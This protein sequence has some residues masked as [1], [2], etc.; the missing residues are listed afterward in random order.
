MFISHSTS[1]DDEIALV[2]DALAKGLDA[3]N[4]T[5]LLDER[6]QEPGR[7]WQ[8]KLAR[9][10]GECDAALVLVNE[11]ALASSWVRRETNILHWRKTL[12]PGM[13]LV[14][15]LVGGVSAGQ[16]R[17]SELRYLAD[18]DVERIRA[19]TKDEV[20]RLVQRF[21]QVRRIWD[22][23]VSAWLDDIGI[24]LREIKDESIFAR[25]AR[26][27]DVPEEELVELVPGLAP[28]LLASQMLDTH[29]VVKLGNA[30][31][32]ARRGGLER[33]RV[34]QLATMILPVWVDRDEARRIVRETDGSVRRVVILN[35]DSPEIGKQYLDRAF[36]VDNR[37]YY[38]ATAAGRP[39]GDENPE[40]YLLEQCELAVKDRIGMDPYQELGRPKEPRNFGR[41]FLVLDVKRCDLAMVHRVIARLHEKVPWVHVLVI[42]GRGVDV[43]ERW[44][45]SPDEV[46]VLDPP[47][48]ASHEILVKAVM[49]RVDECVQPIRR[50]AW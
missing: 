6:I 49:R 16:L 40:D 34:G 42:P 21:P 13:V 25:I 50:G 17:A 27:L 20:D 10:L 19:W 7:P 18:D 9:L 30:V 4:H 38:V 39:P 8:L 43:R 23:A 11:A 36:C 15:V 47:F 14:T 41:L 32:V 45:G 1:S 12:Y 22:D 29:D 48:E 37:S 46:L 31:L 35:V 5:V 33:D 26:E 28:V 2:R 24:Q 44:P 3:R